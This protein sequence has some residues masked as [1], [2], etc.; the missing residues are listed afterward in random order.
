MADRGDSPWRGLAPA[1]DP[2]AVPEGAG[3]HSGVSSIADVRPFAPAKPMPE[4]TAAAAK[5]AVLK[6]SL[7]EEE[8]LLSSFDVFKGKI[9][10]P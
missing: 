5:D 9:P 7:R 3:E 1:S 6:K 2:T 8:I 4:A 10:G